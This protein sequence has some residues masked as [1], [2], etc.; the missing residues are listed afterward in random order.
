M[1]RWYDYSNDPNAPELMTQRRA[2]LAEARTGRLINDRLNYLC[3]LVAGKSVLDIGVVEHTREAIES[4]D[5]L[6]E[7]LRRHA[8]RCV[9]V[10]VLEEEVAY[11]KAKGYEVV[12]GDITKAPIPAK[13]D[14]IIAGEVLEHLDAPGMFMKNCAA[15]LNPGG[16]LVITVPNPWYANV[17]LKNFCASSTFTDSADHVA[18]YDAS[19]LYELAQRYRL[20]LDRY[21]GIGA[22][23]LRT[24]RARL[25]FGLRPILMRLGLSAEVFAKSIIFEF[26]AG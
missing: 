7:N 21:G 24:F 18:W 14:V 1:R 10:D 16:R 12:C 5:W 4:P 11:L 19:T 13:F 9:G 20:H 8:A 23:D 2:A 22:A 25:F 15:M 3:Q 6:H 17:V 26:V